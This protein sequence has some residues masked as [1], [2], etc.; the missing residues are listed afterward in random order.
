MKKEEREA[1]QRDDKN[2]FKCH[3]NSWDQEDLYIHE[4]RTQGW[5]KKHPGQTTKNA[6]RYLK[7]KSSEQQEF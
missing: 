4:R 6:L 5:Q 3:Q 1:S 2:F 7:C